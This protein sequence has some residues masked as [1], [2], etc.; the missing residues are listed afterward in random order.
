MTRSDFPAQ[1]SPVNPA[2]GAAPRE[3][4][5]KLRVPD[6]NLPRAALL[7][8][9]AEFIESVLELNT[10][11]DRPD[12][13]LRAA[14][15][16][17]RLRL[18]RRQSAAAPAGLLTWK[19]P[20]SRGVMHNR[21][22]LDLTVTP[23]DLARGFLQALGFTPTVAF[24]KRRESWRLDDCRVELDELPVLGRF[25]EIEGPDENAVLAARR[26]LILEA[27]PN[28]PA[29]YLAMVSRYLQAHPAPKNT[30]RF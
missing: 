1:G 25:V 7:R 2:G 8:A 10:F 13:S 18:I 22:S 9:S 30:L 17:L 20:E 12:A 28:E 16:G 11:Y 29:T 27:I 14:G 23:A 6:M 19:G 3:I 15:C 5:I 24:E 4:E 26:K 21:A